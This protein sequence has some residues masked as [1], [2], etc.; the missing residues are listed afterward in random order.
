MAQ[1]AICAA[2]RAFFSGK[3]LGWPVKESICQKRKVS[4]VFQPEVVMAGLVL[5]I[6][7]VQLKHNFRLCGQPRGMDARHKAGHD[8]RGLQVDSKP[9]LF[10][11]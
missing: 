10:F 6:R 11:A 8:D 3:G 9:P 4:C 1:N 5:A 7:P 2:P